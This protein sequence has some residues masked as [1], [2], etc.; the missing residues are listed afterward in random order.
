[1]RGAIKKLLLAGIAV[2]AILQPQTRR[3]QEKLKALAVPTSTVRVVAYEANGRYLG[4]PDISAFVDTGNQQDLA[5]RFHGGVATAIPY[6][7]YRVEGKQQ[8]YYPDG[9]YVR[10]YQASVTIVLGMRFASEL[11][12]APPTLPG[13]VV[14]LTGPTDKTFARLMGVYENVSIEA[15]IDSEG[16]FALGGLTPGAF[17]LLI[18]N[19]H[20]ILAS[21][22]LSIPY[23]GPPLEIVVGA[24]RVGGRE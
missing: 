4:A 24:N 10:V 18:V 13:R 16:K 3:Q 12:E 8:W 23:T 7:V 11:P 20:G 5:S 17:I 9:R 19:D 14:G 1:M 6:G 21:R 15:A 2:S 22:T